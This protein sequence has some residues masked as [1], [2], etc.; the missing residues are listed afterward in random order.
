MSRPRTLLFPPRL[1]EVTLNR[2][3]RDLRRVHRKVRRGEILAPG[4]AKTLGEEAI[5][6]EY[7]TYIRRINRFL[8]A[9]NLEPLTGEE[10]EVRAPFEEAESSWFRIVDDMFRV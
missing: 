9:R 10:T 6:E 8:E 3:R 1:I 5:R 7:G 2:L 4:R